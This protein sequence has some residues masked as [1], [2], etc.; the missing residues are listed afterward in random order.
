[1]SANNL[2]MGSCNITNCR[3]IDS[4]NNNNIT[5]ESRGTGNVI[6]RTGA[7]VDLTALQ[8]TDIATLLRIRIAVFILFNQRLKISEFYIL[9]YFIIYNYG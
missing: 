8:R 6:L 4:V 9:L 2:D 5:V 1:L 3:L 7:T